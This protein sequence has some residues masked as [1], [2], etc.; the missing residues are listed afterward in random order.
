[1]HNDDFEDEEDFDVEDSGDALKDM[2]RELDALPTD[3]LKQLLQNL[4][5]LEEYNASHP[6]DEDDDFDDE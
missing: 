5:E 6:Y 1:M 2:V 4:E 3:V